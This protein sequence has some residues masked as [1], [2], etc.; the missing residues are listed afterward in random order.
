MKDKIKNRI[1]RI[2]GDRYQSLTAADEEIM[3]STK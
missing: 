1:N 3:I 2:R